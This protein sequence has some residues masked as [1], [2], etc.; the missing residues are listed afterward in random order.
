VDGGAAWRFVAPTGHF[1]AN[2]P[3]HETR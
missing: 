2:Q 1:F 3:G